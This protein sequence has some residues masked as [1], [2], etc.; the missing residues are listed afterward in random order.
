MHAKIAVLTPVNEGRP[1]ELG[2]QLYRKQVLRAGQFDYKGRTL[3]FSPEYI[4]KIAQAFRDKAYDTVPF[5]LADEQNR[6]TMDPKNYAGDVVGLEVTEDGLDAL[7]SLSEEAAALVRDQPSFGVSVRLLEDL[8][9]GDGAAFPVALQHVLGTFDPRMTGMRPWQAVEMSNDDVDRVLDLTELTAAPTGASQEGATVPEEKN[10]DQ[11]GGLTAD[12]IARLA[13]LAD[14]LNDD[15]TLLEDDETD[16]TEDGYVAPSEAEQERIAAEVVSQLETEQPVEIAASNGPSSAEIELA[17][18][19]DAVE[20]RNA[21]LENEAA[22]RRYVELKRSLAEEAGIPPAVVEM[23]KPWLRGAN[24][25]E[26]SSGVTRDPGE[27]IV[28]AFR[29]LGKLHKLVD[30]SEGTVFGD[31]TQS[32]PS[33][34]DGFKQNLDWAGQVISEYGLR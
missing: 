24:A 4:A 7:V 1:I 15:G 2:R 30:L 13:Q 10:T 3:D 25:I 19:L 18:R 32:A 16:E 22:E 6:H 31:G 34:E 28:K 11:P 26:L 9:R 5:M 27:D 23:C 14:L 29:E 8:Q 21:Q 33:A 17:A 12:Q 20:R